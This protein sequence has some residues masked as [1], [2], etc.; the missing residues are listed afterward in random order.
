MPGPI[1]NDIRL[2][3]VKHH[4][5]GESLRSI[6]EEL[7]LSYNTVRKIWR[8]WGRTGKLEPS[9]EQAKQ[10]GTRQYAQVYQWAVELKRQ[11]PRWGAEL[12]RLEIKAQAPQLALP[13]ARTLQLWFQAAGVNRSGSVRQSREKK[14]QRGQQVHQVW[15][16][17]AKE[18][19]ALA[20]GTWA[21][22]LVLTD[23]ASG[24][25]LASEVFPP[26]AVDTD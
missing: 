2:E 4:R 20:D 16:V 15:A 7:G 23:E 21:S 18:Q 22:W 26:E 19:I 5:I 9:Y 11:H 3:I 1:A 25:I 14:V 6:S 17:D 12:I 24:A 8:H 10:R 13:T